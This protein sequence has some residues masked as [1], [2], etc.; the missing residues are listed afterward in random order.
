MYELE[1]IA[2]LRLSD[3]DK[4]Y[5]TY[6]DTGTISGLHK[7]HK[8]KSNQIILKYSESYHRHV[9]RPPLRSYLTAGVE[10]IR[11]GRAYAV[12]IEY[13]MQI[14]V[15]SQIWWEM[16]F[17]ERNYLCTSS[18]KIRQIFRVRKFVIYLY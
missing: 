4:I 9:G 18:R 6:I 17:W 3:S 12:M 2:R 13:I 11:K 5:S 16:L 15:N 7:F 8:H 1:T 10:A 14:C